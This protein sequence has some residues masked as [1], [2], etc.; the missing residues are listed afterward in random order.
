VRK[1]FVLIILMFSILFISCKEKIH[2]NDFI[3]A[4]NNG[5]YVITNYLGT[6]DKIKL[7]FEYNN[8][9][10]YRVK[11]NANIKVKTIEI[12]DENVILEKGSFEDI[13]IIISNDLVVDKLRHN[14]SIDNYEFIYKVDVC[15]TYYEDDENTILDSKEYISGNNITIPNYLEEDYLNRT[16]DYWECND[17]RYL[18]GETIRVNNI[19]LD[20]K[21]VFK[22]QITIKLN[23][24]NL[25]DIIINKGDKISLPIIEKEYFEFL[26]WYNGDTL[27]INESTFYSDITLTPKFNKTHYEVKMINEEFGTEN[28]IYVSIGE[29]IPFT[30]E[31]REGY[32]FI[33][34]FLGEN[35]VS[36]G[37]EL[38][39]DV[40]INAKYK[41]IMVEI[42][43][44][45][46]HGNEL[47]FDKKMYN[48]NKTV[49]LPLP[50][51]SGYKFMGWSETIYGAWI[52]K[53]TYNKV[54][55]NTNTE[56]VTLYALWIPDEYA[57]LCI[58][59][60][61]EN[62]PWHHIYYVKTYDELVS[63]P[64]SGYIF[65]E[66]NINMRKKE[67]T[68]LGDVKE[69]NPEL[70]NPFKG[71]FDGNGYEI[72]NFSITNPK[73]NN[74]GFFGVT[75]GYIYNLNLT[76]VKVDCT[77]NIYSIDT[78]TGVL[79]GKA[80]KGKIVNCNLENVSI[81]CY[82]G[83]VG[84]LGGM[85]KAYISNVNINGKINFN[86][87]D[88]LCGGIVSKQELYSK[89]Q[90]GVSNVENVNLDIEF[91]G[92]NNGE[93]ACVYGL[94]DSVHSTSNISVKINNMINN[95]YK[96][97]IVLRNTTLDNITFEIS[98]N[99]IT[100]DAYQNNGSV[101]K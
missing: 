95:I 9:K 75:E 5:E 63:L 93:V 25:E 24:D 7:P 71:Y 43:F 92:S 46:N 101:I 97:A 73:T 28:T 8:K 42:S 52:D 54:K 96:I 27:Y 76:N 3:L 98:G 2:Y 88:G 26:G 85:S 6:S 60:T 61:F 84:L 31:D 78:N 66:N 58:Q 38:T 79:F 65:L 51:R 81:N 33:G 86:E 14:I 91:T 13:D 10:V 62:N 64:T 69:D 39:S 41:K 11:A 34:W 45:V 4:D 37:L 23:Y 80:I 21:P 19:D 40:I 99:E 36:N 56:D 82:T 30:H 16:F 83:N 87:F 59:D 35:L 50:T 70:D 72:R 47:E 94:C 57:N 49:S 44:D 32:E 100:N 20:F 74:I 22:E 15:F 90:D 1:L 89:N 29:D 17:E 12:L 48:M 77:D 55:Y 53:Y 67:W 18:P 68:P